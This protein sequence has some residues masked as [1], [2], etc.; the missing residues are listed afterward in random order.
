MRLLSCSVLIL[1]LHFQA[2]PAPGNS[3][4]SKD[5]AV[6]RGRVVA[7]DT[8]KPLRRVQ[9]RATA[10][11]VS[12][13]RTAST[14]PAG[15]FE[16]TGLPAGRYTI[17][18]T[19]GG[20]L[21]MQYGQRRYGESGMTLQVDA[22]R[23]VESVDFAMSR[24]GAITGRVLDDSGEPIAGV[25]V[26]AMQFQFFQGRRQLVPMGGGLHGSSDDTGFFRLSDLAPGEYVVMGK[27]RETWIS[28]GDRP[29]TLAFRR[30]YFPGTADVAQAQRV[31]VGPGQEVSSIE[32]KMAV[33]RAV[34]ISGTA[35]GADGMPL[36][37]SSVRIAE[38]IM[39]PAGGIVSPAGANGSAVV[40]PDGSWTLRDVLPGEIE[41]EVSSVGS[42]RPV[43]SVSLALSVAAEDIE[44]I[45]LRSDRGGIVAGE[46]VA[47]GGGP[48]PETTSSIRVLAR[49]LRPGSGN[50]RLD[51][52]DDD[53][54]VRGG[55]F[56]RRT[57]SGP[58][59]VQAQGLPQGWGVKK[60]EV[61]ETDRTNEPIVIPPNGTLDQVR[62]TVSD[63]FPSVTG[64][65]SDE[66]GNPADGVVLLFPAA[67]EPE[68]AALA[69]STRPDQSGVFRFTLV[70]PG[71][72]FVIALDALP[73]WQV[74]DPDFLDSLRPDAMKIALVDGEPETV[75]LRVKR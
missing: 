18:A 42:G 63:R 59:W 51:I 67:G 64:R 35:I 24:A 11:G 7:A 68:L 69:R 41:L 53:G 23:T 31:K 10:P 5:T 39:G 44:G 15:E 14:D 34:T 62:V 3:Q 47:E 28:D 38:R 73:E 1:A 36:A 65:L 19:R 61:G 74:N 58:S 71:D 54:I 4:P 12:G 50:V 25:M 66:K 22:G 70:R 43:E 8:G 60:I 29:E 30:S 26:F 32:F 72:Y 13:A 17:T 27:S 55:K 9:I 20:Y 56:S 52:G 48:L 33:G 16:L 57:P 6:I 21:R 40:A 49:P 2:G 46:I 45:V 37:G 75:N